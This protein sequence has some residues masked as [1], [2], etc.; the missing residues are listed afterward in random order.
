MPSDFSVIALIS[1]YNEADIIETVVSDLITQGVQVYFMD[2]GS[3]DGTAAAVERHLGRGVVGIERLSKD[4]ASPRF[5]WERILRRKAELASSLEGSWFIHHDAD[6]FRESPWAH[7]SL[8]DAIQHVDALG[9]N[10]I[11]FAGLEFWPVDGRFRAGDDVRE[12]FTFYSELAPYDRVQIRCWKK[13]KEPVDLASSGGHGVQFPGRKVFP[14]RFILRHYPIR[15]QA[16]GERKVFEERQNRFVD[17]ERARGWHVQYDGLRSGTS[18]I[19]EATTLSSYDPDAVRLSLALNPRYPEEL[20]TAICAA[21]SELA[22]ALAGLAARSRD[23]DVRAREA[24]R[25]NAALISEHEQVRLRD[26]LAARLNADLARA[27]EEIH[28]RDAQA[29]RLNAEVASAHEDIHLRD[30]LAAR[31]NAEVAA[32]HEEIQLRDALAARLNGE[33]AAAHEEIQLRDVQAARLNAELAAAHEEIRKRDVQAAELNAALAREHASVVGRNAQLA[34]LSA[35]LDRRVTELAGA[36]AE[37]TARHADLAALHAEVERVN[38]AN[39]QLHG[40]LADL[41]AANTDLQLDAA[42]LHHELEER[43][44]ENVRW[45]TTTDAMTQR[46]EELQRSLSWRWTAPL[47]AMYRLIRRS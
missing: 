22:A 9:Y 34:E 6:E 28:L 37:L 5:E 12:A 33:V 8:K 10:A 7:L 42:T 46:I 16:H 1:A 47:R 39:R 27:H 25:L 41:H 45:R 24:E 3:S 29:A 38:I 4:A 31:L 14:V 23:L 26:A 19:R 2:D 18:F 35:E 32:A 13:T 43:V 30:A 21:R 40:D 44:S 11:D 17:D 20:E 15:G 36:Y